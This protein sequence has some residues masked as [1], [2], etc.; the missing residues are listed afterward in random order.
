M[1]KNNTLSNISSFF[2]KVKWG[3]KELLKIF[4]NEPSYF[5]K[6][7]IESF[8]AFILGQFGMI[9]F[10]FVHINTMTATDISVWAGIEFFIAGYVINQIQKEK[11]KI[12]QSEHDEH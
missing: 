9:Y 6:K 8:T 11:L 2:I 10:L 1:K 12:K 7:R 3:L 5:S 4:S